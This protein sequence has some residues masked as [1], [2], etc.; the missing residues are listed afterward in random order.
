M[1]GKSMID[2][3]IPRVVL[4]MLGISDQSSVFEAVLAASLP[5]LP[6]KLIEKITIML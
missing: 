2:K 6:I 1:A 5:L 4:D 3:S